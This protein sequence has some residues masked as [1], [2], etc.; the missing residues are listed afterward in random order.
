M[1][2]YILFFSILSC[3]AGQ[4]EFTERDGIIAS[5][6]VHNAGW[7]I[8]VAN[9]FIPFG[10]AMCVTPED[11]IFYSADCPCDE[12]GCGG[13]CSYE[14]LV[15][16]YTEYNDGTDT[17]TAPNGGAYTNAV[18]YDDKWV[19]QTEI[20]AIRAGAIRSNEYTRFE[21]RRD[22]FGP[23]QGDIHYLG[24]VDEHEHN[25]TLV[26]QYKSAVIS[27]GTIRLRYCGFEDFPCGCTQDLTGATLCAMELPSPTDVPPH[28]MRPQLPG[29]RPTEE[30]T[31]VGVTDWPALA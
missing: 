7:G 4:D 11:M 5:V 12:G 10:G 15:F 8:T 19:W 17:I 27:V 3:C 25:L 24:P 13:I 30:P 28:A 14:D 31:F 20:S 6:G 29:F 21:L 26:F 18:L 1:H 22:E 2:R 23:D 9:N 16:N